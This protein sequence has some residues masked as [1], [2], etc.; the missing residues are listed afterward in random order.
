MAI[1]IIGVIAIIFISLFFYL[2]NTARKK[3]APA[4][5]LGAKD[6]TPVYVSIADKPNSIMQGM[7]KFVAQV[8]KTESAGDKWRLNPMLV[9]VAGLGLVFVDVV[10]LLFG[11]FSIVFTAGG[12][13][14][15]IDAIIIEP[16]PPSCASFDIFPRY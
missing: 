10:L 2:L 8:Q 1:C 6:Y 7:D 14:L 11:Y 15:S 4:N 9:F 5:T 13:L 16:T 3:T 12:M